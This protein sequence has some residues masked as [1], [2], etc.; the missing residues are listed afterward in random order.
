MVPA[1]LVAF[2]CARPPKN[3]PSPL[4]SAPP[5]IK[6]I[7]TGSAIRT[8]STTTVV[9]RLRFSALL[10]KKRHQIDVL[11]LARRDGGDG[12]PVAV[13]RACGTADCGQVHGVK[14]CNP[15]HS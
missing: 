2:F 6:P 15:R 1:R 9:I 3:E 10:P 4:T 13:C 14:V 5:A 8:P 12:Q 7:D 11:R